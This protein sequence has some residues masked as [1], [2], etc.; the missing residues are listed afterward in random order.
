MSMMLDRLRRFRPVGTPGGV[1]AV[2]VPEDTR[3]GVP[4]ELVAVFAGL[5]DVIVECEA[6]RSRSAQEAADLITTARAEA[7]GMV[8]DAHARATGERAEVSAA[9]QA[10][11]DAAIGQTLAAASAAATRVRQTGSQRMDSLVSLVLDRLRAE[12][13]S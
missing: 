3:A 1:G 2:G 12:V 13:T 5:D 11:G 4:A 7:A 6:I 8:S 10:R 9:I